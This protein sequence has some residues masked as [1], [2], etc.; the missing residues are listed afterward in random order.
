M[1]PRPQPKKKPRNDDYEAATD[2]EED[3]E[4]EDESSNDQ[5][6]NSNKTSSSEDEDEENVDVPKVTTNASAVRAQ[7]A[8][9]LTAAKKLAS[10]LPAGNSL[11]PKVDAM[12]T[13]DPRTA[14]GVLRHLAPIVTEVVKQA[15]DIHATV[16]AQR[17]RS[18]R[19]EKVLDQVVGLANDGFA[20]VLTPMQRLVT[21]LEEVKAAASG[22]LEMQL[23]AASSLSDSLSALAQQ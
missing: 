7:S 13:A 18:E 5:S 14:E 16:P 15:V 1:K 23:E 12:A 17:V 4:E 8:C 3:S 20:N 11:Q 9:I 10:I 22:V 2:L 21:K 19:K 6:S